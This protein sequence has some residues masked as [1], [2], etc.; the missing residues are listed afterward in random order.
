MPKLIKVLFYILAIA[1]PIQTILVQFFV[2]K[3]Q[4]PS[5]LAL[6]KEAFLGVI[7]LYFIYDI[8][9]LV[10]LKFR[11]KEAANFGF[12]L[13]SNC[14]PIFIYTLL[15]FTILVNSFVFNSTNKEVFLYGFRFELFWLMFF[16][17]TVC[18]L[19]IKKLWIT[20]QKSSL[21]FFKNLTKSILIGFSFSSIITLT[22][23]IF[24]QS[25]VLEILGFGNSPQSEGNL[26]SAAS[27]C[28]VVDSGSDTCRLSG[29]FS[30]PNH[31]AGYLL[32]VLPIFLILFLDSF[33]KWSEIN[34]SKKKVIPKELIY[35]GLAI[36][37]SSTFILLT[38][39]RYAWLCLGVFVGVSLVYLG[40]KFK[41]ISSLISKLFVSILFIIPAFIGILA[42]NLDPEL[43]SKYL[44]TAISKPSSTLEHY[45]HTSA[46]LEVLRESK[47]Y[48]TGF[49][50]GSSGSVAKYQY[51]N[52]D[53]NPIFK[54]YG[55]IAYKW[56]MLG[57]N[58]T[59]PENWYL[60]LVL[61]GGVFYAALYL[62][63]VFLPLKFAKS[64]F[65]EIDFSQDVLK[66][67]L[68]SVGFFSILIGNLF[69]HIWENQ[70][71]TIYWTLLWVWFEIYIQKSKSNISP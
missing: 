57:P 13:F 15:I 48:F 7:T 63:L 36:V 27:L 26:I 2:N 34:L 28:N 14:W 8:S 46:S 23:L 69:L 70:T 60:A 5:V 55:Y 22:S 45:R 25:K 39:S 3:W 68:V 71:I 50:L 9:R 52:L 58:I 40:F 21:L 49:G 10:W 61:N 16:A 33:W 44:P 51:Q 54:K 6:W 67:L 53:E 43:T 47:N 24:G 1:L 62:I 37:L 20:E 64:F 31:F 35:S 17:V 42:I 30:T 19:N 11:R 29:T 66:S 12:W 65:K 41:F 59:I 38:V 56:G 18:W 32:L 4:L